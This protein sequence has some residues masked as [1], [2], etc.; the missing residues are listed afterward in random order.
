MC[1][2]SVVGVSRGVEVRVIDGKR[3]GG[4]GEGDKRRRGEEGK[5]RGERRKEAKD[6][7]P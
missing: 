3:R 7:F 2:L 4:R 6:T 5:V 1:I